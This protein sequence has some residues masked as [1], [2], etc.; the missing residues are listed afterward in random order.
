V[1]LIRE[2][3]LDL[4]SLI[5]QTYPLAAVNDAIADM[6]SGRLAGRALVST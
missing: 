2:G 5:G 1:R 3:R 6:R 4:R